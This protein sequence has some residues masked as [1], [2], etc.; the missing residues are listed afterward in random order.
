MDRKIQYLFVAILI[1]LAV[2][3]FFIKGR[4]DEIDI[5]DNTQVISGSFDAAESNIPVAQDNKLIPTKH[6]EPV[7]NVKTEKWI[8]DAS[9]VAVLTKWNEQRGW[10]DA[11]DANHD[12]YKTY[13]TEAL[14]RLADEGDLRALHLLVRRSN[15]SDR[16]KLL[17]KAAVYG[18]TFALAQLSIEVSKTREVAQN[19]SDD[20]KRAMMID[21]LSYVAVAKK[22]GELSYADSEKIERLE[23]RYGLKLSDKDK[24][25]IDSRA[26]EIYSDLEGQRISL[27]LGKFDNSIPPVV[28]SFFEVM[29]V[30]E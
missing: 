18:S 1:L 19:M 2:V 30:K 26:E 11:S 8:G 9:Q 21:A 14:N 27:G 25:K 17:K 24:H 3:F 12:D 13:S 7:L 16:K 15:G 29:G 22:R 20:Q 10:Y 4:T 28:M 23:E 5:N 6:S